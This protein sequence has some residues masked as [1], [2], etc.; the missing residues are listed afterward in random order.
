MSSIENRLFIISSITL[1]LS[2]IYLRIWHQTLKRK[3]E[4]FPGCSL[5]IMAIVTIWIKWTLFCC[6]KDSKIK[7]IR[8]PPPKR[9]HSLR[10]YEKGREEIVGIFGEESALFGST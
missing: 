10:C 4:Y 1:N 3:I 9:G 2:N 7:D 5:E 8:K 6:W